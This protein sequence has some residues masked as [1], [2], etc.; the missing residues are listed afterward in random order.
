[1]EAFR[2]WVPLSGDEPYEEATSKGRLRHLYL[3]QAEATGETMACVVVNGNGVHKEDELVRLL[4]ENVPGLS[5]R[6]TVHRRSACTSG[7]R[8]TQV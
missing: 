6:L 3:R 8:T 1:M 2:A 4:R 5:I 7:R